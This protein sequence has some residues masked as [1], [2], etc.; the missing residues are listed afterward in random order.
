MSLK[1]KV[2]DNVK[3][4]SCCDSFGAG[5]KCKTCG[6]SCS[7]GLKSAMKGG[8]VYGTIRS[9]VPDSDDVMVSAGRSSPWVR[10]ASL[11][12]SVTRK[13]EHVARFKARRQ[14]KD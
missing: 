10:R 13:D 5:Y 14:N 9:I 3:F 4:T 8:V 2:G 7:G 6:G 12:L 1:L 11:L